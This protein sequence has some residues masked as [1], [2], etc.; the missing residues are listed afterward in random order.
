MGEHR[1]GQQEREGQS[2]PLSGPP[3]HLKMRGLDEILPKCPTVG[4]SVQDRPL[5]E[6]GKKEVVGKSALDPQKGVFWTG[7]SDRVRTSEQCHPASLL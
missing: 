7:P 1:A 5:E 3:F 2:L 4:L 6:Q